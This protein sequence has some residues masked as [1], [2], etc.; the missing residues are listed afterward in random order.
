MT[1]PLPLG[2]VLPVVEA[3]LRDGASRA[4]D[5]AAAVDRAL[6]TLRC[7]GLTAV[8]VRCLACRNG[9]AFDPDEGAISCGVGCG[10]AVAHVRARRIDLLTRRPF[11][12]RLPGHFDALGLADEYASAQLADGDAEQR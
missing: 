2:V 12:D 3:A 8:N 4:L 10:A 5:P 11:D 6:G 9:S 7:A 1:A